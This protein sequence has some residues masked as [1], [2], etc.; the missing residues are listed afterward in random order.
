MIQHEVDGAL[1]ERLSS[2]IAHRLLFLSFFPFCG[3]S[4][5]RGGGEGQDCLGLRASSDHRLPLSLLFFLI[6]GR[7]S[8]ESGVGCP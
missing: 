3:R 5:L 8:T 7:V 2:N 6:L 4:V 1:S